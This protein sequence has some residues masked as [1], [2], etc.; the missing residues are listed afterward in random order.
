MDVGLN[1]V[2]SVYSVS[3]SALIPKLTELVEVI[4]T[5]SLFVVIIVRILITK[6]RP[7]TNIKT[8]VKAIAPF[9]LST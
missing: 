8:T 9:L 4:Y 6:Q 2:S 5:S 3:R 1:L 7:N